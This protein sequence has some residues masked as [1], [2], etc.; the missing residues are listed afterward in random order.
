MCISLPISL[1]SLRITTGLPP[2][3][4]LMLYRQVGTIKAQVN[5][6]E[7]LQEHRYLQYCNVTAAAT[8]G[9]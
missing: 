5:T 2:L 3:V 4:I 9:I 1:Q 7:F 6:A 8:K